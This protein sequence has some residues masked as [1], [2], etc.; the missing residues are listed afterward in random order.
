MITASLC[1]LAFAWVLLIARL[2]FLE[3][4]LNM[5][6][7]YMGSDVRRLENIEQYIARLEGG[8]K[9]VLERLRTGKPIKEDEWVPP[10]M[11]HRDIK[12]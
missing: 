1:I 11:K 12:S 6:E 5:L 3:R 4:R 10:T 8:S 2:L 9:D 7:H